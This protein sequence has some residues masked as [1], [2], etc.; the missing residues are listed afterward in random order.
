MHGGQQ[1]VVG[2]TIQL[3]TVGT[4]A[5]GSSATPLLT[6]TVTSDSTGSFTITGLYSCTNATQV[7]IVAT[8]GNPGLST[9][10]PNIALMAALGPCS[11]THPVHLHQHQRAHHCRRRRRARPLHVISQ[12][13]RLPRRSRSL[14]GFT[15]ANQFVDTT[16]G[17]SPGITAPSGYT[18][19]TAELNTLAD[20]LSACINSPGGVAGDGSLCG[21]LFSLTT[22]SPNPAPTNTIAAMLNI[23]N[24][25]TLNTSALYAL[26]P[27]T[28][29]FQPTLL[30]APST[31]Q[32]ALT[33]PAG[34]SALQVTPSSAT[35]PATVVGSS[36]TSPAEN[37]TLTNNGSSTLTLS[38]ISVTGA[39]GATFN[40]SPQT[41]CDTL[42]AGGSCTF[43]ITASPTQAGPDSGT[44]TINSSASITPL[45]VPLSI[46]GLPHGNSTATLSPS[47]VT[48]NIWG[49]N[50][51]FTLA[52]TG[53]APL[54]LG[55]PGAAN[56]GTSQNGYAYTLSNN[57]CTAPIP[58]GSSCTFALQNLLTEPWS[59][60]QNLPSG[61]TGEAYVHDDTYADA[62]FQ[63]ANILTNSSA[64]L[65]QNNVVN[66]TVSFPPNQVAYSQT[67]A[68]ELANVSTQIVGGT[69]TVIISGSPAASLTIGGANPG[70]FSVSALTT[71]VS[72]NPSTA[73]PGG[74]SVCNITV[75]FN[76]TAVGTRT[77]EVSLDSGSSTTGQYILLT[78]NAVGT[79]PSFA[80][81]PTASSSLSIRSF[82][83]V[84]ADP[85]SI[86]SATVVVTNTGTT[87]L[88]LAATFAGPNPSRF[89]ADVSQCRSVAP[90][91]TCS[92]TVTT[93]ASLLGRYTGTLVL[94]D[95]TSSASA[96]LGVASV[97]SDWVPTASLASP[98][99]SIYTF[100]SQ[101]VNTTSAPVSFTVSD[102]NGYPIGDP[103]TLTLPAN[104]NFTLPIG[105]CPA[106]PQTCTLSVAF[107]PHTTGQIQENL[108][109]TDAA[110][111]ANSIVTLK[112]TGT[113]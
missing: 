63:T 2:A 52:N 41:N 10:N 74:T 71:S 33:P 68:I 87:T 35:F 34:G 45:S 83:P 46:T 106:G 99:A 53:S 5:D 93:S 91:A 19:P 95:S 27:P 28:P 43:S 38:S 29:P 21:Q 20:I 59:S 81:N 85:K 1:P 100:P 94:A 48:F 32:I 56:T 105:S 113:P 14:Y 86:G 90:Q 17:T 23:A 107:S 25:P 50:A 77:A 40:V 61:V 16:T 26:T 102:P 4:T 58:A 76:P 79:G 70:D 57:T 24:N 31:F 75:T 13:H 66:G 73:C 101:A 22:V 78:G 96:T 37:F 12:R 49:A 88:T 30:S 97:T 44:L 36:F 42:D 15:L 110:T 55:Y 109:I 82:L 7:Y 111:G 103:I 72:P 104:S 60:Y 92:V 84:N 11:V 18:V 67:A 47:S 54:N 3:Y 112:G 39:T 64:I 65:L 6:S 51:D 62:G 80:T 89:T 9:A 108:L 98:P 8:G 69:P